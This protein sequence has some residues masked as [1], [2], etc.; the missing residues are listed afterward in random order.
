MGGPFGM[1]ATKVGWS[2]TPNLL[3]NHPQYPLACMSAST[4]FLPFQTDASRGTVGGACH[5]NAA[6]ANHLDIGSSTATLGADQSRRPVAR[7]LTDVF[8][9]DKSRIKLKV[10]FMK[11]E[12]LGQ[13]IPSVAG[14]QAAP[15]WEAIM[16]QPD[17]WPPVCHQLRV[18]MLQR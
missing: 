15:E 5:T 17:A 11:F 1:L 10:L 7:E 3:S 9:S 2:R 12:M 16:P 13:A 8:S 18:D 6:D 14:L 4:C